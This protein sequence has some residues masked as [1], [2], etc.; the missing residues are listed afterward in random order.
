MLS[1]GS[2]NATSEAGQDRL[3]ALAALRESELRYRFLDALG[4]ATRSL[5]DSGEVMATTARL[6]GQ[7]LGVTRCAYADVEADSNHFTIRNDWTAPGV[8]SSTGSYSLDLFGP[9][10][11]ANLCSG[12]HLV[13]H[14][15]DQELGDGG[16]LACSIPS[17]SRPSCAPHSSSRAASWP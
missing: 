13:V 8:A 12:K 16:A 17:A 7:Y 11:T 14:D 10:A 9:Q 2:W 15:V 4:E 3:R 1:T 5:V 6:L